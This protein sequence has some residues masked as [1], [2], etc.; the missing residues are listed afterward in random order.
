MSLPNGHGIDYR[1]S[2]GTLDRRGVLLNELT[3]TDDRDLIAGTPWH[4]YVPIRLQRLGDASVTK[5][6]G[7]RGVTIFPGSGSPRPGILRFQRNQ[8]APHPLVPKMANLSKDLRFALRQLRQNPA[9]TL[10]AVLSLALGI[11]A[12]TAIFQLIDAVRLRTL[13]VSNPQDLAYIDFAPK[14]MHSGWTSS[15]SARLTSA[16][17]DQLRTR[18]EGFSDVIAWSA[19][20]FNLAQGGEVRPAEGLY[21][22]GNF[23]PA[24]GVSTVIGRAFTP[25]DDQ[26]GCG[27]PSVVISHNFWQREY[28]GA[29]DILGRT[30]ALD[31]K[32]LPIG[33]VTTPGFF[34][35][36]VGN[37]Y[38]VALPLCADRLFS[39]DGKGRAP[40]RVAWWLSAMGRLKPGW[41]LDRAKANLLALSPSIMEAILPPEYRPDDAKRFLANKLDVT[42][43][44]TGVSQLRRRFENPLWLLLSTAGLVLLI[45]CAN[46]ANLLLARASVRE[47]EIAVRQAIGAS[48]GRLIA[49]LLS[50]SLLLAIFGTALGAIIAQTLSRALVAFLTTRD[51]AIFVGLDLDFRVLGFMSAVA[52]LTCLLFGLVPAI[53]ATNISPASTMRASGRGITAG[54]ERF[55]LRRALVIAQV[56]ISLVL[57][58]GAFL[59]VRSLQKLMEVQPG[60]RAE[61]VIA[62]S[63]NLRPGNYSKERLP[64]VTRDI[65]ELVRTRTGATSAAQVGWTPV[66]GS[67]WNDNTWADGAKGEHKMS[68]YNR[69]APGYFRTMETELIAGRDFDD[70]DNLKTPKV[71][72][73][74]EAFA[75]ANFGEANPVGRSFRT[76]GEAGH[77]DPIYQVVGLVRNTK[78]NEIAEEFQP[79]GFM[80]IA[81]DDGPGQS[82]TF[83][84]RTNTPVGEVT[85]AASASI[86]E[87][88]PGI[89]VQFNVLSQQLKESLSRE[90]LMAALAGAFGILAGSLAVLGLYGVIAYMVARRRNEIGMRI[91]LGASRGRVVWLVLREAALLLSIGL[92]VGLAFSLWAG[93][94]ATSLL[95]GLKPYDPVTLA[96]AVSVLAAVALLAA[97]APAHRAS[98]LDPM[99]AL[100][101]E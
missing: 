46:L 82:A 97:Y 93:Q 48:R 95:Y 101:E 10:V 91:A 89:G 3:G 84:I 79:V 49:Q 55:S 11:G 70:H 74:N 31:G 13:P 60:F 94:A 90:R 100:R 17:Y 52:L 83:V 67:G 28:G 58:V 34:G 30:I 6:G 78:Y 22:S 12:N 26:P 35:V 44:G 21:V 57:L 73:V 8:T 51:N 63:V 23:F 43:G 33:G 65:I 80:P 20:G 77:P 7:V 66:S 29:A 24:L 5:N 25:Q 9:F 99:D 62:V 42:A 59:F 14:S 36:E 32:R 64:E 16:L 98:R 87:V 61:G 4:K 38:D 96:T 72:I 2:D 71:A 50:E 86:A 75:K 69:A 45:A 19:S 81:Q 68:W 41:T 39:D 53:R 37:R 56:A 88:N 40:N 76:E 85:R 1:R 54:P 47:K 92:V 27:S 18:A 15:R